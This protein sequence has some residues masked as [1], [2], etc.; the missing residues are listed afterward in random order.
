MKYESFPSHLLAQKISLHQDSL[1]SILYAG[2][3]ELH[4]RESGD[5]IISAEKYLPA[6]ST[7][8]LSHFRGFSKLMREAAL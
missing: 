5:V 6:S 8:W 4:N 2:L 7:G 1:L 3:E